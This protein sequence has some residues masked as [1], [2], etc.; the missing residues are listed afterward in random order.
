MS[1]P[2]PGK[3]VWSQPCPPGPPP[4]RPR[5]EPG[6]CDPLCRA[7]LPGHGADEEGPAASALVTPH[8][9]GSPLHRTVL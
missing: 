1:K 5:W 2:A 6:A 8:V 4:G 9:L 3:E 7:V